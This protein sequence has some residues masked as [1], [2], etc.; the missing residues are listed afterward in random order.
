MSVIL[1]RR[2]FLAG[3]AS[4][5][6]APAIVKASSIMQIKNYDQVFKVLLEGIT[7]EGQ[8]VH[9]TVNVPDTLQN[10]LDMDT[11]KAQCDLIRPL[12]S[13][14]NSISWSKSM[15][16]KHEVDRKGW[17]YSVLQGLDESGREF[18]KGFNRAGCTAQI[19]GPGSLGFD[20]H[21]K[22][23]PPIEGLPPFPEPYDEYQMDLRSFRQTG[24]WRL[25]K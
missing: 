22:Q 9:F 10:G 17:S 15:P 4:L 12:V 24:V 14:V 6:A 20:I 18:I 5:I 21:T 13:M 3:L 25:T 7:P 1:A 19:N 23:K 16:L 11:Y 8:Q 2:G